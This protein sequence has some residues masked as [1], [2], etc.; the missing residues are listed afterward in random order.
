M[1]YIPVQK[2]GY[3]YIREKWSVFQEEQKHIWLWG[4]LQ[5][6]TKHPQPQKS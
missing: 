5:D 1:K 2:A 6:A 4:G 3:S